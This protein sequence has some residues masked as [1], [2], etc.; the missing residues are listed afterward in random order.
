MREVWNSFLSTLSCVW[1]IV[2]DKA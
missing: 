2:L 1:V